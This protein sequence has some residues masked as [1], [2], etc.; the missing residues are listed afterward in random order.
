MEKTVV[1][2]H[3]ELRPEVLISAY[4]QGY[5]P[6]PDCEDGSINWY[7]PDPRAVLPL[8]SFH[9][10][11]SLRRLVNQGQYR[12]TYSQSFGDVMRLC[13]DRQETWISEEFIQAYTELHVLSL[14]HSVEIWLND[15]LAGGVYGVA[16]RAAFFAES[17]FHRHSNASK[18]ALYHLHERLLL[19]GY[20][21]FEC[22]FLTPHLQS[23]GA[24]GIPDSTYQKILKEALS[25]SPRPF[26]PT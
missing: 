18:L 23:L 21:L 20:S 2:V 4:A 14:A 7:R 13:A 12:V 8:G 11:R 15:E 26:V 10:S 3:P 22:Q 5:F 17:M 25:L 19:C 1:I 9:R 24:I 16:L 6:M